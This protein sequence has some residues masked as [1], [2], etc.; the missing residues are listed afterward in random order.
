MER[1]LT[2]MAPVWDFSGYNSITSKSISIQNRTAL[3]QKVGDLVLNRLFHYQEA[4]VPADFGTLITPANV[5]AHLA[6]FALT[7]KCGRK[8]TNIVV[9]AG[10]SITAKQYLQRTNAADANSD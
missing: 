8:T 1:E 3:S 9:S 6:K 7:V 2:E 5:E 4:T 10:L